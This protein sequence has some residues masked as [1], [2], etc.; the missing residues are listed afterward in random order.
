MHA[1]LRMEM[2]RYF[3]LLVFAD[4]FVAKH[5]PAELDF[6]RK[7]AAAMVGEAG[8]MVA[9]DPGPVEP[10]GQFGQQRAST[11]REPVAAERVVEAVSQAVEP[12][13]AGP[14]DLA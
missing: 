13:R 14:L 11:R 5:D 4:G 12:R 7:P 1:Q 10:A 9:D 8:V 6:I 3:G 2:A